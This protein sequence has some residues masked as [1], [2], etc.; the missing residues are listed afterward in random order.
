MKQNKT[1][2]KG[3]QLCSMSG[4]F[5][6][7]I[8]GEVNCKIK[9]NI[10]WCFSN[11]I[12][13]SLEVLGLS[14]KTFNYPPKTNEVVWYFFY[15]LNINRSGYIEIRLH[16]LQILSHHTAQL[17]KNKKK[18]KATAL[19]FD[20]KKDTHPCDIRRDPA[21]SSHL[22]FHHNSSMNEMHIF[23]KDDKKY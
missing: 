11:C 5:T 3:R 21:V 4:D 6:Y 14:C 18:Q 10:V 17:Q 8:N 12:L 9:N 16:R 23:F 19:M 13:I 2:N 7:N 1:K 15:H 22:R 20:D